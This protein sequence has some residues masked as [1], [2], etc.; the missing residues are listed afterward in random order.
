MNSAIKITAEIMIT[1]SIN[2]I[3]SRM[4]SNSSRDISCQ[5]ANPH[6]QASAM[7]IPDRVVAVFLRMF[8]SEKIKIWFV[9]FVWITCPA[10]RELAA[11][12][13]HR[14]AVLAFTPDQ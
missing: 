6:R 12:P 13:K 1:A 11:A 3:A 14:L 2:R 9:V 4:P 5:I 8:R 7:A 10:F